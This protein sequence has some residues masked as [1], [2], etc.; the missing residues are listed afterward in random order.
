MED[1]E[2][3]GDIPDEELRAAA[4]PKALEL[5]LTDP[6][7]DRLEQSVNRLL[8]RSALYSLTRVRSE[9]AL[10][11]IVS[12]MRREPQLSA[13]VARYLRAAAGVNE[14]NVAATCSLVIG[15]P[16]VH[17]SDWQSLWLL[18]AIRELNELPADIGKWISAIVSGNGPD[19]V[20]ARAALT[21][22]E[23]EAISFEEIAELYGTVVPASRPDTIAAA[24]L[25][26]QADDPRLRT[27]E[28]DTKPNSWIVELTRNE[29]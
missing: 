6:S 11:Q 5:A 17:L 24:A 20:R 14:S 25:V 26:A 12:L 15:D 16:G 29:H 18:E 1:T 21:L 3:E 22:A 28:R 23:S 7:T 8:A 10:P 4:A 2:A 27:I 9:S 13:D 19:I